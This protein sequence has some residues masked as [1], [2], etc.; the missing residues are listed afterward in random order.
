MD[1]EALTDAV[2]GRQWNTQDSILANDLDW[3]GIHGI[4]YKWWR[5]SDEDHDH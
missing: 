5:E 2:A 4:P 3:L 1:E